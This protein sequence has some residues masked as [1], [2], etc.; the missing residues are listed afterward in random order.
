[1]PIADLNLNPQV[2]GYL[3]NFSDGCLCG[4]LLVAVLGNRAAAI[5]TFAAPGD[6]K[7]PKAK[8]LWAQDSSTTSIQPNMF[9]MRLPRRLQ[10]QRQAK[11]LTTSLPAPILATAE[12]VCFEQDRK[13][14]AV[15]PLSGQTL[16][17]RE[18]LDADTDLFGDEEMVFAT[19]PDSN[20]AV[21]I[22]GVDGRE[23]GRRQ[24]P[25]LADRV[26]TRGRRVLTWDASAK[27]AEL[28][29]LDPWTRQ[30]VW[31]QK[32]SSDAHF[33]P[34]SRNALAVLDPQGNFAVVNLAGGEIVLKAKVDPVDSLD[35]IVV[36]RTAGRY[37]L[38]TNRPDSNANPFGNSVQPG[39]VAVGGRAHGFDA[40]GA[41]LWSAEIPHQV[42]NVFQPSD[43]PVLFLFR[44]Y[45]RAV[46]GPNGGFQAGQMEGQ[47]L[48]LDTRNGK[49]LHEDA[50]Q[51]N[52]NLCELEADPGRRIEFSSQAQSVT[53]TFPAE[54]SRPSQ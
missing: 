4:H 42:L 37:V 41:K 53:L 51:D 20:E 28:T 35:G 33:W 1:M 46:P 12:Y 16:W 21:V 40:Q 9:P 2:T 43:L 15:E 29:L 17:A 10:M 13:L 54:K 19:S 23:L 52:N 25:A 5:D 48:C 11:P 8:L 6:P 14:L 34:I 45:M 31:Q 39:S 47:V 44:Q 30:T 49:V 27:Q 26:T 50:A 22:S 32:F 18:G 36:F 7:N 38:L 24:V 3:Y